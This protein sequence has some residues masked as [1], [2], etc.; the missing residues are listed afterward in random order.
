MNILVT[1]GNTQT[2]IDRVR[3]ITNIFSGRT[4]TRIARTACERGHGVTL[5]TSQPE[6][7]NEVQNSPAPGASGSWQV[8]TYRTFDDLEARMSE[9]I[10]RIRF[11]AIVH[12]AAVSDYRLAGIFSQTA[13]GMK[14]AS[15]GKVKSSH[16]ELWLRLL[17]TPKLIDKVRKDWGFRGTLVKFKLEV[18]VSEDELLAIA[19]RSRIQ[20]GAD[21][22]A[23]NTLDGMHEWAYVGAGAGGYLKIQRDRLAEHLLDQ[24]DRKH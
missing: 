22:M 19:E 8:V 10:P 3:C 16:P 15:A 5:L 6:V 11:D 24:I 7:V 4:G 18:G 2:P 9:L 1:A 13:E 12:A 14:D 21:L 20:S 17:P 23:A